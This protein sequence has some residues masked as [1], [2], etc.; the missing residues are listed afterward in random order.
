MSGDIS[1]FRSP[2]G[3]ALYHEAYKAVLRLWPIPFEELYV[4][5][6]LGQTHV[7]ASGPK[8][9]SPVLLLHP[10][11]CSSTIWYRNVAALSKQYKTFAVDTM[12]EVNLSRPSRS[13][14]GGRDFSDWMADLLDG[15]KLGRAHLVGNSFGAYVALN[16]ALTLPDRVRKV[17]LISPAATFDPMRPLYRHFSPAYILGY[18]TGSTRPLLHAYEWTWQ[19]FPRDEAI[20]QLRVLTALHGAMRHGAPEVFTDDQ[21]RKIQTPI[22]LLIGDH[23]VVYDD[24]NAVIERAKRLIP[25]LKAD[26]VPNANHNAEYTNPQAVNKKILEFFKEAPKAAGRR[27]PRGATR[28]RTIP[29]RRHIAGKTGRRR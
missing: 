6:R 7:I 29:A 25:Q 21:L 11:G 18:L 16:T 26:R 5:T 2:E 24:P 9:A 4:P 8:A 20:A 17:V 22:L 1:V 28:K 10:A 14:R 3:E 13:I 15:L 19:G 12:S 27:R 23:E